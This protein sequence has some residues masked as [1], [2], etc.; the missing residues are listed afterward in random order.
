M[1]AFKAARLFVPSTVQEMRIDAQALDSLSVFPF[2]DTLEIAQLKSE[3]PNYIAACEDID[4][5]HKLSGRIMPH[6]S[7]TGQWLLQKSWLC[8]HLRQLPREYF[9]F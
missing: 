2:F 1:Q 3:L 9:R 8:S 7:L 5:L 6:L 4:P